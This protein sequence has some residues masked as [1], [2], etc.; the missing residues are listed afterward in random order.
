MINISINDSLAYSSGSV[1]LNAVDLIRDYCTQFDAQISLLVTVMI[2]SYFMYDSIIPFIREQLNKNMM[3][4]L[5]NLSLAKYGIK[6][7]MKTLKESADGVMSLALFYMTGLMWYQGCLQT[8]HKYIIICVG[9]VVF[10][11]MIYRLYQ[12]ITG[13]K[14][15]TTVDDIA[16]T[17]FG[18]IFDELKIDEEEK[19]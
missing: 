13:K 11:L 8:T 12:R 4:S 7:L 9:A 15:N 16:S 19:R 5:F 17:D 2:V 10:C 14:M 18:D 3:F 6:D 1:T